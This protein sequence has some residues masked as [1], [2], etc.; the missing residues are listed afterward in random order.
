MEHIIHLPT[1]TEKSGLLRQ[2]SKPQESGSLEIALKGDKIIVSDTERIKEVLRLVMIKLGLRA[3]NWPTDEEKFVLINHVIKDYGG[4]TCEEILL[5]FDMAISGKLDVEVNCYENFSCLYF[6][7][8]MNTYRGWAKD[9]V[10]QLP[11]P[12]IEENT[13]PPMSDSEFIEMNR[14]IYKGSKLWGL[15]STRVYDLLKTEMNLSEEVKEGIRKKARAHFFS[16][17]ND[18]QREGLR[19]DQ[20]EKIINDN[21]KR[22]AVAQYWD[23]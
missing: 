7:A 9:E 3:Q 8:I 4:H 2:E 23:Q 21:A 15:I 14:N 10:K 19:F 6:S 5:A 12:K 18:L 1:G 17:E 22:L 16:K 13:E 11:A 20:H